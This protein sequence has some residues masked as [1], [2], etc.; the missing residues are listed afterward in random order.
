VRLL[1]QK[2]YGVEDYQ[3]VGALLA[4]RFKLR[5]REERRELPV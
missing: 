4:D 5:V 1:I 2:A 3:V